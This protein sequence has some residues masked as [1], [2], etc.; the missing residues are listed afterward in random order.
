MIIQSHW[1][2]E[3]EWHVNFYQYIQLVHKQ[4]YDIQ[5]NQFINY[6]KSHIKDKYLN[7]RPNV[8]KF[9]PFFWRVIILLGGLINHSIQ[10]LLQN[11]VHWNLARHIAFHR[12][13]T[14]T[15]GQA[16]YLFGLMCAVTVIYTIVKNLSHTLGTI[17]NN[18]TTAGHHLSTTP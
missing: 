7:K 3:K 16:F 10:I 5:D 4:R 14:Q 18:P 11:L 1:H 15:T 2:L 9:L 17:D 6:I 8:S 12:Q 13:H